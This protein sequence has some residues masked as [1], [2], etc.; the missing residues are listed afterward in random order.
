MGAV[1]AVGAFGPRVDDPQPGWRGGAQSTRTQAW[2]SSLVA[3]KSMRSPSSV[4]GS[5][6]AGHRI[7]K[8]RESSKTKRPGQ[9]RP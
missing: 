7:R 5:K 2:R 9:P 4:P 8:I 3:P 6:L 1:L